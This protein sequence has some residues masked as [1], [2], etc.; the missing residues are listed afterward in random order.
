MLGKPEISILCASGVSGAQAGI[1]RAHPRSW[2]RFLSVGKTVT[3]RLSLFELHNM[4]NINVA[5]TKKFSRYVLRHTLSS[6]QVERSP[7]APAMLQLLLP[8]FQNSSGLL[9][10]PFSAAARAKTDF[11]CYTVRVTSHERQLRQSRWFLPVSW[12]L[13]VCYLHFLLSENRLD[14]AVFRGR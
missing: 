5:P 2:A 11:K 12:T 8:G 13:V 14:L 1:T 10:S 3:S 9:T 7:A 4:T 6:S